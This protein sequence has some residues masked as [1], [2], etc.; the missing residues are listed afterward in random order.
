MVPWQLIAIFVF[1]ILAVLL[2]QFLP[3]IDWLYRRHKQRKRQKA[4]QQE[5]LKAMVLLFSHP[6]ETVEQINSVSSSFGTMIQAIQS[7]RVDRRD[8]D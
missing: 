3:L 5:Y 7:K 1:G 6:D 8:I 2:I 4:A